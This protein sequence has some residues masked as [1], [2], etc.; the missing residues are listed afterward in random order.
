M[1]RKLRQISEQLRADGSHYLTRGITD[2]WMLE[3]AERNGKIW[4]G[5]FH[6]ELNGKNGEPPQMDS[7]REHRSGELSF[8][9]DTR[10]AKITFQPTAI[11]E[12]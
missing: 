1:R 9:I 12:K 6:V 3:I 2:L 10:T 7:L 11:A 4:T 8:A 5:K